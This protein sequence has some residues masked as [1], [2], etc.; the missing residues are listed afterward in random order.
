MEFFREALI[1]A[2]KLLA[3]FDSYTY[4][5]IG[6]SLQVSGLAVLSALAVGLPIGMALSLAR[7]RGRSL[8]VTLVNTG[9]GFPPVVMGLFLF[10]LLSQR[11]PLGSLQLLFSPEAMYLAQLLLAL[12]FII[13][14]TLSGI[15]AVPRE[16]R[17]QAL[18]LGASRLQS[19]WLILKEARLSIGAAVVAAFG[20]V[21]SEVGAV[22]ILGGNLRQGDENV[23]GVMTTVIVEETR[24]G[25]FEGAL[26]LGLILLFLSFAVMIPITRWQLGAGG[27][28]IR[29]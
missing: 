9:L 26:A 15:G 29:S 4:Q 11:G 28:W 27:R 23:T 19:L 12:P 7:F 10:M 18:G 17:L 6:L 5:V 14:I 1:E 8:L 3:R 25:N 21:I 2:V 20:A 16:T 24:K 22:L 13:S